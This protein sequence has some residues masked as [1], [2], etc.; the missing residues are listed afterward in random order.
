VVLDGRQ[1]G[2]DRAQKLLSK[3]AGVMLIPA[4]PPEYQPRPLAE[5]RG[6]TLQV[7]L[8]PRFHLRPSRTSLGIAAIL[9]DPT[10]QFLPLG[11]GYRQL[12][13]S[14][15]DGVPDVLHQLEAFCHTALLDL[16]KR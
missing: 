16:F 5:R 9:L 3:F 8:D 12:L 15:S 11:L 4:R 6:N 1:A 10:I 13:R 7:L 2:I 14:G